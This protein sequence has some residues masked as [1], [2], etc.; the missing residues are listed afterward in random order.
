M[1]QPKEDSD[2]DGRETRTPKFDQTGCSR[3]CKAD[4]PMR[5]GMRVIVFEQLSISEKRTVGIL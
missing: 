5:G 1:L 4:F 2:Q 3:H